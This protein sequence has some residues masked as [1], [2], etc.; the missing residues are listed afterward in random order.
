MPVS[1][2]FESPPPWTH[3]VPTKSTEKSQDPKKV[4]AS[5]EATAIHDPDPNP[6]GSEMQGNFSGIQ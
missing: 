1:E 6:D 3:A 4:T 5:Q 2:G